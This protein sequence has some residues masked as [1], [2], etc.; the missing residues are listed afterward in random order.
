MEQMTKKCVFCQ[1]PVNPHDLGS[2]KQVVG[3]VGGPR[4]DGMTLRQDTGLYAHDHCVQK[5]KDGQAVDQPDIFE[6]GDGEPVTQERM[7]RIVADA[8]EVLDE[9]HAR[10]CV[11]QNDGRCK[12]P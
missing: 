8:F 5:H 10:V 3:W 7:D 1:G 9:Y 11:G 12:C 2:W 4:K 6:A